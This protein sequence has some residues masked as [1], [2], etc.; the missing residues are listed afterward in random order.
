VQI[1]APMVHAFGAGHALAKVYGAVDS[2]RS[3]TGQG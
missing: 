1:T 3:E 2:A